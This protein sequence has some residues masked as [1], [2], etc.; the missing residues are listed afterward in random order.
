M[1]ARTPTYFFMHVMKT[2]GTTFVQHVEA[3]F[4]P[5]AVYPGP[6]RGSE[7][8]RAYFMIDELRQIS[9]ERRRTIRAYTGHFPFVA[10][11]FTAADTVLAILRDPVDRTLSLLR[12]CKRYIKRMVD[13]TLEE[14]YDDGWIYP[15]FIHNYQ[16]KL[17]AMT[18]GDKLESQLDVIEVDG[19]RL[20]IAMANLERVDVLGLHDR[21]PQ[22]L[23]AMRKQHGW[24]IGDVPDQ[25]VSTEQWEVPPHLPERIADDNAADMALYEHARQLYDRRRGLRT[26]ESWRFVPDRVGHSARSA[27]TSAGTPGPQKR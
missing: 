7:R 5:E 2:G 16:A 10:S 24:T 13:M 8:L 22:F 26:A 23:E 20:E 19:P 4:P 6:Q 15:L 18:I 21:Y 12:H 9:P 25:R 3:N 14:I 17:F 27:C 1:T 11:Q